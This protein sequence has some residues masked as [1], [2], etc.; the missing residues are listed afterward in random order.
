V[1]PSRDD[2]SLSSIPKKRKVS[3]DSTVIAATIPSRRSYSDR[4]KSR[5]WSSTEEIYA[6]GIRNEREFGYDG[7]NWR[8]AKEECDFMRCASANEILLVHPVHFSGRLS[9]LSRWQHDQVAVSNVDSA[10]S[11]RPNE[12]EEAEEEVHDE[13]D[14]IF[15]MD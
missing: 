14:G 7:K 8:T 6:N 1:L 9:S 13:L 11:S 2:L 10:V 4:I 12:L 5:I 15:D 3:F